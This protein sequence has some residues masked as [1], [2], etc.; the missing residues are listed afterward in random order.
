M[1]PYLPGFDDPPFGY[2]IDKTAVF[3]TPPNVADIVELVFDFTVDVLTVNGAEVLPGVIVTVAGIVAAELLLDMAITMP[4]TGAAELIVTVPVLDLPPATVVGFSTSDDK[5]GALIVRVPVFEELPRLAVNVAETWDA[6][7]TVF[8]ANVAVDFPAATVTDAG[9]VAAF[10]LLESLM[11]A[12]PAGADPVSVTVP[13]AAAP[14]ATEL[15]L[16]VTEETTGGVTVSVVV[17][18]VVPFFA[19]IVTTF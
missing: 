9:T 1:E 2:E 14:P 12:P 8:T 5:V 17:A 16:T 18:D 3:D 4:P 13:V 10:R 7:A 11:V 19:V 15:G 6:T